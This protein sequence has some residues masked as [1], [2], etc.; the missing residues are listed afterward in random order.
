MLSCV[1]I[2][3][4]RTWSLVAKRLDVSILHYLPELLV[5]FPCKEDGAGS[6]TV[7]RRWDVGHRR[8]YNRADLGVGNGR[9]VGEPVVRST[10][11]RKR[12]L[13]LQLKFTRNA[14]LTNLDGFQ[15]FRRRT[16]C[17]T[18]GLFLALASERLGRVPL[19]FCAFPADMVDE[20]VHDVRWVEGKVRCLLRFP[21]CQ[22]LSSRWAFLTT[23]DVLIRRQP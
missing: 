1:R 7:E 18:R 8:L 5:R 20:I 16:G 23:G 2:K 13:I 15:E 14:V 22:V 12:V 21:V 3:R 4:I 6:L 19:G 9:R 17:L 10:G 11:L